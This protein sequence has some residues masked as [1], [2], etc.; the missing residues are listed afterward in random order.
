MELFLRELKNSTILVTGG[1]G[2]IG[3]NICDFLVTNNINVICLDNLST[4]KIDN[5]SDLMKYDNFKFIEADIT[6]LKSCNLA[7]KNVDF[8]MI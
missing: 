6:D 4:G 5:I 8:V 7:C 2:F 1:A 3:S